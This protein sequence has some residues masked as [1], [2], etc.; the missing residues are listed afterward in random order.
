MLDKKGMNQTTAW[1]QPQLMQ[2]TRNLHGKI[3]WNIC[4]L[5]NENA[6]DMKIVELAADQVLLVGQLSW[7]LFHLHIAAYI[8]WTVS[9]ISREC[10]NLIFYVICL[11]VT[12]GV[13]NWWKFLCN[14]GLYMYRR[15]VS[16]LDIGTLAWVVLSMCSIRSLIATSYLCPL[17]SSHYVG[18][19]G[20]YCSPLHCSTY[21]YY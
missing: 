13:S 12:T 8:A 10:P 3:Q 7:R 19:L 5:L 2:F 15:V 14:A 17:H 6:H 16:S 20:M 1:N 11:L 18:W 9:I 21:L 4:T